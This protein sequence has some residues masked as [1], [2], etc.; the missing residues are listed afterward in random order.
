M[1]FQKHVQPFS[2]IN[3]GRQGSGFEGGNLQR[4]YVQS[5]ESLEVGEKGKPSNRSQG[6]LNS[7]M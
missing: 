3:G 7:V 5:M 2:P 1:L 6:G 4:P